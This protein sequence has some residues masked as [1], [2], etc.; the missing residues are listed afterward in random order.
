MLAELIFSILGIII[1]I[2][3]GIII[4]V[5][6]SSGKKIDVLPN[7]PFIFIDNSRTRFTEGYFSGL[8][9]RMLPRRNKTFYIEFF[10]TD[11]LQGENIPRPEIQSLIVGKEFVKSLSIGKKSFRRQVIMTVS[12]SKLDIPEE[13]R[14]TSEGDFE[15]VEG[16]KA[17][18]EQIIGK[19]IESGDEAISKQVEDSRRGNLSKQTIKQLTDE[20][21]AINKIQNIGVEDHKDKK[22]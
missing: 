22:P 6:R 20:A 12:R 15:S 18:L 5:T 17:F 3:T 13:L 11:V 14:N 2:V 7:M 21:R 9:K 16:Q 19:M 1:L 8:L 4:Y 10:P